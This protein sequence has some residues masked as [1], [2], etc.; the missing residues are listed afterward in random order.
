MGHGQ[1][2]GVLF[3]LFRIILKTQYNNNLKI[4]GGTPIHNI[5]VREGTSTY[6]IFVIPPYSPIYITI[7]PV[8]A[9]PK[10]CHLTLQG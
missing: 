9:P 8:G 6:N 2:T 3:S 4:N 10:I 7:Y 5:P 1:I